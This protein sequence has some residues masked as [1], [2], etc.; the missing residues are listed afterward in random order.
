M[1]R[2]LVVLPAAAALVFAGSASVAGAEPGPGSCSYTLSPP[3]VAQLSGTDMVTA[4]L[5]PAGCD[6][7]QLYLSVACVQME[8]SQGARQCR[9][10]KGP[11]TV[12]VYYSPYR[13]GATY[14]S[15]GK[16]C[17]TAGNPPTS[18][19]KPMGPYSATL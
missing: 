9:Q 18:F 16:G 2:P 15:T 7:A 19:C 3:H 8:G 12:R 17:A 11:N 14:V 10:V 4:T 13:P 1:L 6:R 5:S